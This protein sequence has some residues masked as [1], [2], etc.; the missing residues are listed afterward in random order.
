MRAIGRVDKMVNREDHRELTFSSLKFSWP[1]SGLLY[2][3][4][5]VASGVL[6]VQ[7]TLGCVI[8]RRGASRLSGLMI[9][10]W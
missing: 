6:R 4:M 10:D 1:P 2:R 8:V 7:N 3:P 5:I 9:A